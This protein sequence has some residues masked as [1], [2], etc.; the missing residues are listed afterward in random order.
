MIPP[1][2]SA[3][4]AS[5]RAF[6][7]AEQITP[8]PAY[9]HWNSGLYSVLDCVYSSQARYA[10]VVLPLLQERFPVATGLKDAPDLL[11]SAFLDSVGAALT[12]ERLEAYATE[13]MR[14]RQKIAGRLKV[15]VA[16][17]V[18]QFF[19]RRG[20]ETR[21][22]LLALG[23]EVLEPLVLTD[24]VREVRGIGPVLARYLLLLLGL[25]RHVKP[26]TL[27]TRLLGRIGGWLP[28]AGH[29][30]DMN[31]IREVV[32]AVADELGTTPA[33]LDQALWL[34]ESTRTG[35]SASPE[36]P[37]EDLSLLSRSRTMNDPAVREHRR[38]LLTA[39]HHAPLHAYVRTLAGEL[40]A[41][42]LD[43][44][45]FDPLGGG[46]HARI[47]CLLE[48]PGPKAAARWGGSGFISIDN[49]DPTAHN[50]F[51]LT[52][53]AGVPREWFLAWNIVP[54]YVGT[55]D[56]IRPVQQTEITDGRE[57][58]RTLMALLPDLQVVV[59]LGRAAADGWSG[60]APA[61]PQL[62]T[63]TTWHP[64][65]QSLNPCP[66]RRAHVLATLNLA[67][68]LVAHADD[69][70]APTWAPGHAF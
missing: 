18:C 24:L 30:G 9:V 21:A 20:F 3:L 34:Y 14:T 29:E 16:Y 49:D 40:H 37:S 68:Q 62:V 22:D 38:T 66:E 44:P 60:L 5:L 64:S 67:R 55:G 58:L 41:Q 17:D 45:E 50:M 10:Q 4:V 33:L 15:E 42:D 48:A 51:T 19:V 70:R 28:R 56:S 1:E 27:L 65:G 61:F 12:P 59:T 11:F 7:Q 36:Q 63:L 54:W 23:E 31:L 6:V 32:S 46:V 43:V 2:R 69:S 52:Q 8:D 25:E 57:H 35:K 26:D 47:L 13:T 53:L 39:P